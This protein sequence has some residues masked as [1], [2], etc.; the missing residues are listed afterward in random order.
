[1][2]IT[3]WNLRQAC[4]PRKD[5]GTRLRTANTTFTTNACRNS[6][7][8]TDLLGGTSVNIGRLGRLVPKHPKP[9][10]KHVTN[11]ATAPSPLHTASSSLYQTCIIR[12]ARKQNERI[13]DMHASYLRVAPLARVFV[14]TR[15]DND[16]HTAM[17]TLKACRNGP[18][19]SNEQSRQVPMTECMVCR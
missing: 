17:F 15:V 3:T 5:G 9:R 7:L 4:R 19:C 8:L 12:P 1:M 13:R 6:A 14:V 16:L 18:R 11:H 2:S 10:G